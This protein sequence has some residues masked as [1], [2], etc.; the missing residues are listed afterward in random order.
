M[1]TITNQGGHCPPK[2]PAKC[3]F[4]AT[5]QGRVDDEGRFIATFN[6]K[7]LNVETQSRKEEVV[8]TVSGELKDGAK[9]QG[10]D[11]VKVKNKEKEKE[12]GKDKDK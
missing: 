12:K 10:S 3:V 1:K 11:T 8:F 6:V 7:D 9:F 4:L 2:H 5:V